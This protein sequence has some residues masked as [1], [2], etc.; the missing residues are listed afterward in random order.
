MSSW[1]AVAVLYVL[2]MGFF[3][4]LGG[5]SAAGEAFRRWG[6]AETVRRHRVVESFQRGLRRRAVRG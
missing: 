5:V 6:A 3:H 2:G 1:I 4:L